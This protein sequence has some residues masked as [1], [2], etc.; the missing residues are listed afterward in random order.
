[1]NSSL[2]LTAITEP[3]SRFLAKYHATLFFTVIILLLAGAILSLYM[4]V[5]NTKS[6]ESV[7]GEIISSNF[8]QETANEIQQLRD[9]NEPTSEL[10]YPARSNP[11]VE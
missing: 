8:D 11:F 10:A 2:S 7:Q 4:S 3:A 5:A 1:M 6:A 9:S